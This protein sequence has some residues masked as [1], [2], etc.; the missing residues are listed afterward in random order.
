MRAVASGVLPSVP[1]SRPLISS[2]ISS[3]PYPGAGDGSTG[4]EKKVKVRGL[5]HLAKNERDT[6]N[7]LHAAPDKTACAPFFK[8]RRMEFAE[9]TKLLRKSGIWGTPRFLEG[10]GFFAKVVVARKLLRA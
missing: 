3:V 9:P 10:T 2:L 7:F 1:L 5:P 8:E 6:P 4:R